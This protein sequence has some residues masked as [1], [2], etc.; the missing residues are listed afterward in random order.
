[1]TWTLDHV[2]VTYQLPDG[3]RIDAL[4]DISLTIQPGERLAI[5]GSNGSG[6]SALALCLAGLIAPSS[7]RMTLPDG[8]GDV[9]NANYAAL[10]FQNPDDNLIA[11]TVAEE[12]ALT[13]EH[14]G[15]VEWAVPVA[16]ILRRFRI[17]HLAEREVT[18]L[19]GGEKQTLALACAFASRRRL[20]VLD[21]PTSHLDPPSRRDLLRLLMSAETGSDLTIILITQ[22]ADE[23]CQFPRIVQLEAG[24]I[25]YDGATNEWTTPAQKTECLIDSRQQ[26]DAPAVITTKSLSQKVQSG[27]PLPPSPLADISVT[28]HAGDAIGLGGPIGSGKSTLAFHLSGLIETSSD[29]LIPGDSISRPVVLIQFPERQLF[30]PTVLDDVTWGPV[31]KGAPTSATRV[32]A[33]RLLDRLQ[34]PAGTFGTRSPFALSGG[35]RRRVALAGVAACQTTL[36]I[37]DEPTAALDGQGIAALETLLSD[38]HKESISYL[39]ISHDLPW[40]ARVTNRLWVMEKGRIQYDGPWDDTGILPP[41]LER[42]GFAPPE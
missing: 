35:Q 34:L 16:D 30:C 33:A 27:W 36:Y 17:A 22:Y 38:W 8:E 3:T 14:A 25:V 19:S 15:T 9:D 28:I 39:I 18:R 23:A 6:K 7:G 41:L 40:L 11:R 37:L 42:L 20:V 32:A 12:I 10:V 2:G 13:L 26:P 21:E 1:M 29:S 24:G 4:K 5:V 31:Q